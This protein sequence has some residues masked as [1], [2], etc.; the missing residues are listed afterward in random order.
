MK[1]DRKHVYIKTFKKIKEYVDFGDTYKKLSVDDTFELMGIFLDECLESYAS[2]TFLDV[3]LNDN[4][5]SL[6]KHF[7][8]GDK[9]DLTFK[10]DLFILVS[11]QFEMLFEEL[12]DE[13]YEEMSQLEPI[14]IY[15][16]GN[17][18]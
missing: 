13:A 5:F 12:F 3:L 17:Y 14:D 18:A 1:L 10:R 11:Q 4:I 9:F 2:E 8:I 7:F 6:F 16:I 15:S